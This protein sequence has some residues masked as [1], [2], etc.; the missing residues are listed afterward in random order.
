MHGGCIRRD[1]CNQC[2]LCTAR[3]GS[4]YGSAVRVADLQLHVGGAASVVQTTIR[5][6]DVGTGLKVRLIAVL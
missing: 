2:A 4:A 5:R 1:C 6:V 3:L